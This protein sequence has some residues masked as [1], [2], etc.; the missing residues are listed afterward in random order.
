LLDEPSTGLSPIA[1]KNLFTSLEKLL[2]TTDLSIIL[3]EQD[4]GRALKISK[5]V[6]LME[7]GHVRDEGP[8]NE[9]S[10]V[11]KLRKFYV[12]A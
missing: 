11:E 5:Y 1:V 8:S 12:G 3:V 6:Y 7:G 4:V 9:F 2:S 10:K